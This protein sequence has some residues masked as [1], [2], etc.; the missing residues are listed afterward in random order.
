MVNGH[1]RRIM[2]LVYVRMRFMI[3]NTHEKQ[4]KG[5]DIK[6]FWHLACR[7]VRYWNHRYKKEQL[8]GLENQFKPERNLGYLTYHVGLALFYCDPQIFPFTCIIQIVINQKCLLS[9]W[10]TLTYHIGSY[11]VSCPQLSWW[12]SPEWDLWLITRRWR[13]GQRAPLPVCARGRGGPWS[14]SPTPETLRRTICT[15]YIS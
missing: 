14:G 9:D 12:I 2:L 11:T 13:A 6:T 3:F 10:N 8:F 15:Q 5:A 1:V 7:F 4:T